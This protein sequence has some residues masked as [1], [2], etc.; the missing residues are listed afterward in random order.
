MLEVWIVFRIFPFYFILFFTKIGTIQ[1]C[2]KAALE[3]NQKALRVLDS[4]LKIENDNEDGDN[5]VDSNAD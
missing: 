4:S 5:D 3:F 1:S 2:Q